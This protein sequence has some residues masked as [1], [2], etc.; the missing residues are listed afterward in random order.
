MTR[1]ELLSILIEAKTAIYMA[2][3]WAYSQSKLAQ[4]SKARRQLQQAIE[5]FSD[6][7]KE[8]VL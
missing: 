5:C 6:L 4:L 1:N 2:E 7:N 8:I 3:S